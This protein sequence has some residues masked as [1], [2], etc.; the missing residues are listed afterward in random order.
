MET[1]EAAP[2]APAAA[3]SGCCSAEPR[4]VES[5]GVRIAAGRRGVLLL[6]DDGQRNRAAQTAVEPTDQQLRRRLLELLRRYNV[7]DYAASVRVYAVKP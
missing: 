4:S 3:A 6:V 5:A 1:S 7:N 2:V